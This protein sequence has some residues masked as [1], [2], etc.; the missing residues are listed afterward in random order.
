[1]E[2]NLVLKAYD[3]EIEPELSSSGYSSFEEEMEEEE[4][5]DSQEDNIS[6]KRR[7]GPQKNEKSKS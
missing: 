7:S 3:K 1:M 5:M 6:K 4:M 2:E